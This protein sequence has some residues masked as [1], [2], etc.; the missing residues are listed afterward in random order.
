MPPQT[1]DQ[2][3]KQKNNDC[4]ND[5]TWWEAICQPDPDAPT[6]SDG[7]M[8]VLVFFF[9]IFLLCGAFDKKHTSVGST[10]SG[11]VMTEK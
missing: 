2:Q 5:P 7:I 6:F 3:T 1:I 10:K 11:D 9:T 8:C 4:P